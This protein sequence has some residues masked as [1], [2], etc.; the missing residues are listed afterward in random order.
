MP[1]LHETWSWRWSIKGLWKVHS[2]EVEALCKVVAGCSNMEMSSSLC[3]S[4][5]TAKTHLNNIEKKLK[6]NVRLR[7]SRYAIM[8]HL[9]PT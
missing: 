8:Y 6:A 9:F 7:A 5:K 2:G 3:I 1:A 4:L